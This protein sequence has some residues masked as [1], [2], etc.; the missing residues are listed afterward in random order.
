ME[1]KLSLERCPYNSFGE[2]IDSY[3]RN[4]I[5]NTLALSDGELRYIIARPFQAGPF[6]SQFDLEKFTASIE[7]QVRRNEWQTTFTARKQ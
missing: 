3:S 4:V 6:N 2:L 1:D 7:L 5:R